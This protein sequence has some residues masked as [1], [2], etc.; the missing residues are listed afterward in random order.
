MSVFYFVQDA[1]VLHGD[2]AQEQ[3]EITLKVC[4]CYLI[5]FP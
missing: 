4:L 1:Q 5:I 3:R 2:I